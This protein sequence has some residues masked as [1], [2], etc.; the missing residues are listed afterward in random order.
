[1][2]FAS[3]CMARTYDRMMRPTEEACLAAWR[4]ELLAG[5]TGNVLELGAGTG[6]NLRY[7]P[8]SVARL[9]VTEPDPNMRRQLEQRSSGGE[10][11]GEVVVRPDAADALDAPSASFDAVVATLVLCSVPDPTRALAEIRRV[12]KPGGVYVFLEHVA[13]HDH[14]ERL[15]WQQRIEPF[16][17]RFAGNC[18]LTRPTAEHIEAAGFSFD[19]LE[20]TSMRKAMPIVRPTVRGIARAPARAPLAR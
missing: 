15:R 20:R 5:L 3:W 18:H 11:P 1:M 14:P 12:L 4:S 7:Y 8:A 16:W 17:K 19:R 2:G 10:G 9:V 6:L 13:A